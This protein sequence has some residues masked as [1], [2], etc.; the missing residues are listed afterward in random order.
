MIEKEPV[1]FIEGTPVAVRM[2]SVEE[3][4]PH[5]HE[6]CIELL[7]V[8]KGDAYLMASYD[9]FHMKAGEFVVSTTAIY[10]ISEAMLRMCFCLCTLTLMRLRTNA[11]ISEICI[12]SARA[13]M[14]TMCREPMCR[15]CAKLSPL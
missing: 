3:Y 6:N 13:L 9:K 7:L 5:Y 12:L 8:L 2:Y 1:K 14:S 15:S 11:D 4:E 10:T